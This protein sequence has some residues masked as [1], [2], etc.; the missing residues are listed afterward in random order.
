[1]NLGLCKI[2][3]WLSR[4]YDSS[5]L[6]ITEEGKRITLFSLAMPRLCDAIFSNLLNTLS[7]LMLSGYAENAVGATAAAN[8][9]ISLFITLLNVTAT[10]TTIVVGIEFGRGNRERAARITGCAFLATAVLSF[11]VASVLTIFARPILIMMNLEADALEY[12]VTYLR[13]RAPGLFVLSINSFLSTMLICNANAVPTMINGIGSNVLHVIFCYLLLYVKIIPG[14]DGTAAVA[15]SSVTACTIS[16]IYISYSFYKARCPIKL[17]V[18]K[19]LL[20]RIYSTAL[21]VG[22]G[23]ITYTLIA[24]ITTSFMGEIGIVAL[25][26]KT[27]IGSIVLYTY[28]VG[29][30]IASA[31]QMITGR[32]AGM[33][34]IEKLKRFCSTTLTITVLINSLSSLAVLIC[35]RPLLS[36][37]T[38]NPEIFAIA[39]A[40]FAIDL[41]IEIARAVTSVLGGTLNACRDVRTTLF[42]GIASSLLGSLA[43]S[44][45]LGVALGMGLLGCWIAFAI[46]EVTKA[47]IYI[48]RY[49]GG[50]WQKHIN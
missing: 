35:Y 33:G 36:L 45:I 30:A 15:T 39:P 44:Y 46:E 10:G 23:T 8:Q 9:I 16:L 19:G 49:A 48:L 42:G 25:N 43:F 4:I 24:T 12:G 5:V 2:K 6:T 22:V 18:E 34:N 3:R 28:I 20:Y 50:K 27:Y 37:F 31:G 17:C 14:L 1:M 11:T 7:T 40:I 32:Y 13:I 47:A 29:S 41:L 26:A 38:D 21:P